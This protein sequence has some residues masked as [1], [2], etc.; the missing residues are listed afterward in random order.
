MGTDAIAT[1]CEKGDL[2]HFWACLSVLRLG[3]ALLVKG[4]FLPWTWD[5]VLRALT[6]GY[7]EVG[8]N[9]EGSCPSG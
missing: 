3:I 7:P 5:L 4:H 2:P 8:R 1:P 6:W 9:A